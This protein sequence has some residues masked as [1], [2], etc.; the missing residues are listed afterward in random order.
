MAKFKV[1]AVKPGNTK[2]TTLMKALL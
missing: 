2:A 1:F